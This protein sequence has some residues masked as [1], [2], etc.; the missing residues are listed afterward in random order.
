[1]L[2]YT[3]RTYK[4]R[5]TLHFF[6]RYI[7]IQANRNNVSN[8]RTALEIFYEREENL[9]KRTTIEN[10]RDDV[11][12]SQTRWS[13]LTFDNPSKADASPFF[14]VLRGTD[15]CLLKTYLYKS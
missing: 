8:T 15:I 11:F 2:Y 14:V 1:M 6:L 10:L 13:F 4:M 7:E 3:E 12:S 5:C 9:L